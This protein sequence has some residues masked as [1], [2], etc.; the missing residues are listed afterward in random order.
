MGFFDFYNLKDAFNDVTNEPDTSGKVTKSA[1]LVGKTLFNVGLAAGKV[2]IAMA[3][4]VP[5]VI[6]KKSEYELKR[7]D[8]SDNERQKWTDTKSKAEDL[9]EKFKEKP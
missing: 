4:E 1:A 9:N 5:S 3:K 6:L 7:T 2:S 8:I